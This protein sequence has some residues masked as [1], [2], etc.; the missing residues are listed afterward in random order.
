VKN[1]KYWNKYI[2]K[3]VRLIVKDSKYVR[4]RDGIFVDIDDTHIFLLVD[5][6]KVPKPFLREDIKRVELK[7]DKENGKYKEY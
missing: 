2:G 5:N 7:K 4:P 1:S 3:R 6:A